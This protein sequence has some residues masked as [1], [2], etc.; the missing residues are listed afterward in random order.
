MRKWFPLAAAS[1]VC[2]AAVAVP[3]A[4]LQ[5]EK[6]KIKDNAKME[7]ELS[8]LQA[9]RAKLDSRIRELR[10]SMGRNDEDRVIR[11]RDGDLNPEVRIEIKKA[12]EEAHKATRD[13]LKNMPEIREKIRAEIKAEGGKD[14]T[15][16]QH[17]QIEKALESAH[18]AVEESL[19]NLPD[20]G[21]IIDKELRILKDKDGNFTVKE[22]KMSPE[23]RERFRKS[24]EEMGSKM[25]EK[26]KDFKVSVPRF[27]EF[28]SD[29]GEGNSALRKEMEDL[30]REMQRL[31]D[32][33]R[34]KQGDKNKPDTDTD[35]FDIL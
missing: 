12:M 22:G 26:M 33:I 9:Q 27:R 23:E 11:L 4:A 30:R 35:S 7:K 14:L 5:D 1:V 8:D 28:N 13:V 15:P 31:R 10:R 17:K 6:K 25:R 20:I 16:E 21:G 18:I 19:K 32:E 3:V 2:L 34:T 24:M 29:R